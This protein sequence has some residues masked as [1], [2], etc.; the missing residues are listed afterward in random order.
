MICYDVSLLAMLHYRNVNQS[1]KF[2]C[3]NIE[4]AVIESCFNF[5]T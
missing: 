4:V 2:V 1:H 3:V 5:V